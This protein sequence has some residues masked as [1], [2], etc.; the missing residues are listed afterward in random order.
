MDERPHSARIAK[1]LLLRRPAES[2]LTRFPFRSNPGDL[3]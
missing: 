3:K 2:L 1:Q